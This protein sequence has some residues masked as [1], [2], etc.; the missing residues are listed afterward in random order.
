MLSFNYHLI[1]FNLT[2][3]P[4]HAWTE[5]NILYSNN[6]FS[7]IFISGFGDSTIFHI[8]HHRDLVSSLTYSYVHVHPSVPQRL[9]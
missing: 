9:E 7:F 2:T 3:L 5:T 1:D 4:F 6:L 8:F